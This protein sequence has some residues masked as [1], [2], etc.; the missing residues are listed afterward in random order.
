MGVVFKARHQRL[1]KVVALKILPPSF[2]RRRD[3]VCRFRR[4]VAVTARLSHPN[5]V[6]ALD[7]DEDRGVSFLTMEYIE[8]R[9]LHDVVMERGSLP[10]DQAL[11]CVIQAARGLEAAHAQ[12]IV[13]RDI[14]PGNMMLDASGTVRVLDLGLARLV[15]AAASGGATLTALTQSGTYLGT[16]A[17]MAPE[18][19][20]DSHRADHRAD[21][22]SLGCTFYFLLTGQ[23][24]FGGTTVLKRLLAHS[25]EPVTPLRAARPD[26]PEALDAVYQKM[27]AKRPDDRPGSMTAVIER[28]E[29]CRS[30]ADESAQARSGLLTIAETVMKRTGP[31]LDDHEPSIFLSLDDAAAGVE[32]DPDLSIRDLV[33]DYRTEVKPEPV[34]APARRRFDRLAPR[35]RR[36]S[37]A[38]ALASVCA[39][40][41]AVAGYFVLHPRSSTQ[42]N[43]RA[44]PRPAMAEESRGAPAAAAAPAP[45]ASPA[46]SPVAPTP[47]P[48]PTPATV[49]P[50]A[51]PVATFAGEARFKGHTAALRAVAVTSDGRLA[52][53]AGLDGTARLWNVQTGEQVHQMVHK[54]GVLDLAISPDGQFALTGARGTSTQSGLLRL[55]SLNS[56]KMVHGAFER[57]H[58]GA[59]RAVAFLGEGR[60]VSGGIDGHLV[61]YDLQSGRRQ[62]T[63]GPQP[64]PIHGRTLAVFPDG[65]HV[66]TAGGDKVVHVWDLNTGEESARWEGHTGV[67]TS[68]ALA[69]DGSR[70][71]TAGGGGMVILW[72]VASGSPIQRFHVPE[73]EHG[74]SVAILPSGNVLA[75]GNTVGHLVEWD[76]GSGAPVRQA[77]EPL[78]AHAALAA[79]PDGRILTADQDN[80]V[81]IWTPKP[82]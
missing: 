66:A 24:P 63:Y 62:R 45:E 75:A 42:P 37:A 76:P 79:L 28:L 26:V 39:L 13:H 33:F 15:E 78:V 32:T 44:I 40:G 1:G 46:P 61:A 8:G 65:R 34:P 58:T 60:A 25:Q 56:G 82:R 29:S 43:T 21:I 73:G 23:P 14:K 38:L 68:I 81:R 64:G 6:S 5:I 67:I 9:N 74:P 59:I 52:L 7:A 17:F 20:E 18:Q 12:G 2:A 10:I 80:I 48:T 11:D 51:V 49:A 4:E 16:A 50:K 22:Y 31:R 57:A 72:N 71:A 36:R 77:N 19:A 30:S 53:S 27:M 47:T 41:A 35:S 54:T 69:R 3:L 55:W 70:A